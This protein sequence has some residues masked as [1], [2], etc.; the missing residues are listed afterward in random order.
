MVV[1]YVQAQVGH[2]YFHAKLHTFLCYLLIATTIGD[3]FFQNRAALSSKRSFHSKPHSSQ[4]WCKSVDR[5]LTSAVGR[6]TNKNANRL[7]T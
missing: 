4:I 7:K 6:N 5:Q 3:F 1:Y 2:F